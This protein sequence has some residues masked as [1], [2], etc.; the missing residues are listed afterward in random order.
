LITAVLAFHVYQ[1]RGEELAFLPELA[2][3]VILATNVMLVIG[4][5]RAKRREG[6]SVLVPTAAT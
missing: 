6:G 2:F 3:A 4:S 1:S 5:F